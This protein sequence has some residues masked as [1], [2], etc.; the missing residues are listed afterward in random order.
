MTQPHSA[1][2]DEH[3]AANTDDA[4]AAVAHFIEQMG[5]SAQLD[6]LPRIAGRM[7][8]YFIIRGGP[9]SFAQLAGELSVSRAS[10]STNVRMLVAI[11]L[12]ERASVPGDRQDYYQICSAPY[13]RMMDGHLERLRRVWRIVDE[14]NQAIPEQMPGARARLQEMNR[15][16]KEAL[17]SNELLLQRLSQGD[18]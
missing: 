3:D 18:V 14:A 5:L 17:R 2:H 13:L 12:I 8:G 10:I 15:F 7:A 11:G 9:V 6:G 16:Y 1:P 4:P